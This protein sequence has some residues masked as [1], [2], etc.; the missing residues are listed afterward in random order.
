MLNIYDVNGAIGGPIREDK[1]WFFTAHWHWGQSARVANRYHNATQDTFQFTPDLSRPATT[2]A[3]NQSDDIRFTWQASAKD[4][5]TLSWDV[6]NNC[7]CQ[8]N[9]GMG[10]VAWEAVPEYR[11]SPN[12]LIQST[13]TRPL[14]NKLLIQAGA[15]LLY[16]D[17]PNSRQQGVTPDDISVLELSTGFR[18]RA[19]ASNYRHKHSSQTNQRLTVS[20]STGSHN[21]KTGLFMQEGVR[22]P[23]NFVN[24]DI[25]Y[26]FLNGTPASLTQ[27]AT[28]I[29]LKEVLKAD[30]GLFAQDQW[31]IDRLTLNFGLR[32]DYLNAD[33][34]ATTQPA[35][36]F[37]GSRHFEE[38]ECIPCWKDLSPR[39]AASY[40]VFGNGRTAVKVGLGRYVAAETVSLAD[41][42]NPANTAVY[43][44]TRRWADLDG[45]F[46]PDCELLSSVANGECGAMSNAAFGQTHVTTRLDPDVIGGWQHRPFNWQASASLQHQVSE[47][48]ALSAGYYRTWYGNFTVT[49][50]LAVTPDDYSPYCITAPSAFGL[51]NAGQA[52]CGMYDPSPSKFGRVDNVVTFASQFGRQ[53][54][55]YN[56]V[57]ANFS[58]R[59]P[60]GGMVSGGVNVGNA[61][62]SNLSHTND[63]FVVDSPEQVRYCDLVTPYQ[64]R[65]KMLGS[66]PLPS[67]FLISDTFQT[68]PGP[69]IMATYTATN[70]EIAPSLGRNLAA[71]ARGT[72]AFDLLQPYTLFEGRINQ[73]D[74]RIARVF[75]SKIG[76]IQAMFDVYNIFNASPVTAL[77]NTLGPAWQRPTQILDARIF[78]FGV[79]YEF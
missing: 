53:T 5:V 1:L 26:S 57:D 21:F 27:W 60:A 17:Y 10:N 39:L 18:Y 11:Y 38:V 51:P 37:V 79:Q 35:G 14:T 59:L 32:F 40:D 63:C 58:V 64:T 12:Y 49:D 30:L 43:S 47:H 19:A 13:W 48:V 52:V 3:W 45:D 72:A 9:L 76:R 46:T 2:V 69:P 41:R 50:N 54:E 62:V 6:Q 42:Y 36:R 34:A 65:F 28:P 74:M 78:K 25:N 66:Y 73:L 70:A 7:S 31:T 20:Y 8:V 55:V 33:D 23:E 44:V 77:I 68:L 61:T 16:F 71:G 75:E 56:G 4:K 15:T 24:Q 67:E 29:V 22:K